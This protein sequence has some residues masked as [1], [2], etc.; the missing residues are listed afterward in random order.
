MAI[1]A[2]VAVYVFASDMQADAQSSSTVTTKVVVA[3]KEIPANTEIMADMVELTSI[4]SDAVNPYALTD[5]NQVVGKITKSTIF[6]DEQLLSPRLVEKGA[7]NG[8][9]SYTLEEG[10]RAISVQVDDVSGVAGFIEK[11]D[12]VDV[13]ATVLKYDET[14]L[15]TSVSTCLVENLLVLEVGA[16]LSDETQSYT[17]V[18]L[19]ATTEE[20]L[21]INYATSNGKLRLVL[22]PVLDNKVLAPDDYAS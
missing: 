17:T 13:I 14:G 11:G 18:T 19:S 3:T 5:I 6:Y 7:E 2:G 10:Q 21:K 20:A 4:P 1:I 15:G 8:A 12:Y 22:R 16:K 9:L